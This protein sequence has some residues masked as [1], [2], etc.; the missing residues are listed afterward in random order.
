MVSQQTMIQLSH[1]R[2]KPLNF[3]FIFLSRVIDFELHIVSVCPIF[4]GRVGRLA[5]SCVV[6]SPFQ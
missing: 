3:L 5:I 1:E 6:V 2:K 4:A